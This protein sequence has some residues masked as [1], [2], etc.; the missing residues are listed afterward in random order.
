MSRIWINDLKP[1]GIL[2]ILTWVW[3]GKS[4]TR[5][6]M[7]SYFNEAC[8]KM[9][10]TVIDLGGGGSPSYREM[11]KPDVI[12][13]NMD[14]LE[15]AMPDFVG[16]IEKILPITNDYADN[17]I[18]LNTLEHVFDF[19]HVIREMHRIVKNSG[20]VVVF[21]PFMVNYHTYQG[22][23]FF[24]D[25]YFRYT[26]S[27]LRRIFENANFQI[28]KIRPVG[29]LF[30]VIADLLNIAARYRVI[31]II[32]TILCGF[33]EFFYCRFRKRRSVEQ[34]PLGYFVEAQK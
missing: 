10:G 6:F 13:K 30:W 33:A 26:Q 22:Q 20:V 11:F 18:L 4:I 8:K 5:S 34:F 25:D 17:I 31:R 16:D 3:R 12:F 27:G 28:I 15:E 24:V 1:I 7:N 21:V 14:M 19:N 32:I 9:S 23:S 2:Q 29:G